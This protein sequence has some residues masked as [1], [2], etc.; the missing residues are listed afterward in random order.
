MFCRFDWS[1]SL[2]HDQENKVAHKRD[3]LSKHVE[4]HNQVTPSK[5]MSGVYHL[6]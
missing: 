5:D 6:R 3:L 1:P 4:N 2:L